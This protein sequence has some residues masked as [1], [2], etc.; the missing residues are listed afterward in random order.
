MPWFEPPDLSYPMDFPLISHR[1]ELGYAATSATFVLAANRDMPCPAM[2][3]NLAY[4][5]AVPWKEEKWGFKQQRWSLKHQK[6]SKMEVEI[7][8]NAWNNHEE[9]RFHQHQLSFWAPNMRLSL[10]IM[11]NAQLFIGNV[12]IKTKDMGW[13]IWA[14]NCGLTGR[15]P[16]LMGICSQQYRVLHKNNHLTFGR[17]SSQLLRRAPN[18]KV[19]I[20]TC[21]RRHS[22]KTAIFV[23]SSNSH[24]CNGR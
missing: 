16:Y 15:K 23:S 11:G 12:Y 9:W 8:W 1:G 2:T 14:E 21:C 17:N 6:W 18:F 5:F 20:Q 7:S 13:W 22:K 24:S 19:V 4:L 10:K 3:S